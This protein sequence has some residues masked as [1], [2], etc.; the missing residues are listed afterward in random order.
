MD[1]IRGEIK[2]RS[3][4]HPLKF[5]FRKL[6]L[7]SRL[8]LG[9]ET[10]IATLFVGF[11]FGGSQRGV[12]LSASAWPRPVYAWL[13]V[14]SKELSFLKGNKKREEAIRRIAP[15]SAMG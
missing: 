8:H 12:H 3:Q 6:L 7:F 1:F 9:R 10:S 15:G 14:A 11:K 13:L 5:T 4:F 2:T